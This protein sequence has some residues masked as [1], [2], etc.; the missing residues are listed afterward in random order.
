M[1]WGAGAAE[2]DIVTSGVWAGYTW[3]EAYVNDWTEQ[4]SAQAPTNPEIVVTS[5]V[6]A[7]INSTV[8]GQTVQK[9]NW[10]VI[11]TRIH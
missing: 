8:D 2:A 4:Q 9:G 7:S 3:V 1:V 11:K 10:T 6:I 5:P